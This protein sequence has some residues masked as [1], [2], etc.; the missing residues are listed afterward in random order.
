MLTIDRVSQAQV[1]AQADIEET[2]L[3]TEL[4]SLV[5]LD[6]M[7]VY[8]KLFPTGF[9]LKKSYPI[10][11]PDCADANLVVRRGLTLLVLLESGRMYMCYSVYEVC[12]ILVSEVL[13]QA[14]TADV[15]PS[16]LQIAP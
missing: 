15:L 14:A 2:L 1:F 9:A 7:D 4:G 8:I 10:R 11:Y 16:T 6:T 3:R 12:R 13:S 5:D